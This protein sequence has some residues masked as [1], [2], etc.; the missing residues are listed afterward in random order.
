M[1]FLHKSNKTGNKFLLHLTP[2]ILNSNPKTLYIRSCFITHR[3]MKVKAFILLTVFL[4]FSVVIRAQNI[5]IKLGPDDMALNQVFTITVEVSNERLKEY[6]EFPEIRGFNK[7]GTSSSS[8]T[9]IVNGKY[10]FIQSITQNYAPQAEGVYQLKPFTMTINGKKVSAPGKTIKVGPP[11]QQQRRRDPFAY[12][13]FEDFFGRREPQQFVEVKDEA[14]LALTVDKD[15]VYVGEGFVVTLGFYVAATNRADLSFYETGQQL[16]EIKKKIIPSNCWEEDFNIQRLNRE[17]V[18]INNKRYGRYKIFQAA[19]YPFNAGEIHFPKVGLKMIKYKVAKNPTFF[20][21]NRKEDFKMFYSRPQTVK[22]IE[23][24]PHPLRDK[25]PVGRYRLRESISTDQMKTGQ[26][27]DYKFTVIGEGNISAIEKPEVKNDG[28]FDFYPPN[29]QQNI[30]RSNNR[31][32]GSKTF[33]YYAIPNEPGSYRLGD[34][35]SLIYFDPLEAKY[36]TLKSKKV[37]HV[38]GESKRNQV[39][40]SN[41]LGSFYDIIDAQSNTLTGDQRDDLVKLLANIFLLIMLGLTI[42]FIFRK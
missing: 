18:I 33:T 24:P 26:S 13:P 22:V 17:D 41:D 23:L 36:D 19:F 40:T 30:I 25:V 34:Y 9:N 31:V 12:D 11:R 20:G 2:V 21:S 14:F 6:G 37:I 3:K 15:Q 4:S 8:S 39:I 1:I 29:V 32:R 16:A 35:I 42:F 10:S 5:K 27:F 28:I 7:M 38:T